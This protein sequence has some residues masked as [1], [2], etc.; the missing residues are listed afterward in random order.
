MI[1]KI[2]YIGVY[3][4][5]PVSAITYLAEVA[6]IEPWKDTEKYCVNF[7]EPAHDVVSAALVCLFLASILFARSFHDR[8]RS[9]S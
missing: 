3:Q 4:V 6:S 1:P 7:K 8:R 5:A 9:S 2:R